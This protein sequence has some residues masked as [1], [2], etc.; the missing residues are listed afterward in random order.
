MN[1]KQKALPATALYRACD[2]DQFDFATTADLPRMDGV[3]GQPRALEAVQFG[4][5]IEQEGYNIFA[6]GSVGAGRHSLV[7]HHFEEKAASEPTPPDWCYVHNFVQPDKPRVLCVPA[8]TGRQ[9]HRDMERLVA[10]LRKTLSSTFESEE[11]QTRQ[12]KIEE[13]LHEPQAAALARLQ[14]AARESGLAL[15]RTPEGIA[16]V[17]MHDDTVMTPEQIQKLAPEER[18]RLEHEVEKLQDELLKLFHQAPRLQ[19]QMREQTYTLNREV[20]T[21]AVAGLIDDLAE[22]YSALPQVIAYLDAVKKEVIESVQDFLGQDEEPQENGVDELPSTGMRRELYS[23]RRFR[24][25]VLIDHS[26]THGAPVIYEDH[27][28]HPNLV[29]RLDY[30]AQM[31]V[32]LTDFNLLKPGALHRANGGYLLLDSRKLLTEPFAWE[33]LKRALRAGEIAIEA[34][35]EQYG[36]FSTVTLEPEPIPLDVK[37]ALVGEPLLYYLLCAFDPEFPQLF[38]VTADFADD[39]VRDANNQA[40]Y[41]KLIA[42][43]VQKNKLHPFDRS[44]VARVIEQS[45]RLA[46]DAGKLSTNIQSLADLLREADYWANKRG[47][48]IVSV[49]DV[50]RALN[51]AIYRADRLREQI[52]E[53]MLHGTLLIDTAGAQI[54]QINGL[55]FIQLGAFAFGRPSRITARIQMGKGEVINVEREV[56]LSGPIHSKGVLILSSFLGARYGMD[57]PLSLAASLVFE[58]SYGGVEGDSASAAELFALL[59]AIAETPITQA[60]AVTGSVNQHGQVQAIGGV[61][62]K[63]EGFFDLCK[64]R[65]LTGDQGVII[66]SANLQHLMLRWD[67]VHAV[68]GGKFNVYAIDTVDEGIELLTGIPAGERDANG[69]YPAGALNDRVEKKLLE[70]AQKRHAFSEAT[71]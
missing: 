45:A 22:K 35:G 43:L 5:G 21:Y 60:L 18:Q 7:R 3:V 13:A 33:T 48:E 4:V 54:G 44:A 59:S 63:I 58:Q 14:K 12:H 56:E 26:E 1:A 34:L 28:T 67:V 32:L 15:L 24:V 30:V 16:F 10:D 52:Q 41:V 39:M 8:G 49:A 68:A 36:L 17:P 61:N 70:L 51:A 66:P 20:A 64:A 40:L 50:Q 65:G 19:R 9:L 31:G 57:K 46:G 42:G 11:Y 29:G 23:L 69:Q 55:S 38:K 71:K 6:L 37:V 47:K 2:P 62:E 53:E 27:P 25:N